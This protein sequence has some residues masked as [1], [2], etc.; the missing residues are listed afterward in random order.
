MITVIWIVNLWSVSKR[1]VES[2]RLFMSVCKVK[3]V[4][5]EWFFP[6]LLGGLIEMP[7]HNRDDTL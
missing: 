7:E 2:A 3:E 5:W 1:E 6:L 4:I